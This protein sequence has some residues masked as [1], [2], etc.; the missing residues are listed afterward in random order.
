MR[1]IFPILSLILLFA[2]QPKKDPEP[3]PR[4][5]EKEQAMT[6]GYDSTLAKELGADEFGMRSYI[7]VILKKGPTPVTDSTASAEM[8]KGH[9]SNMNRLAEEGKLA[10]AGP[11]GDE[12]AGLFIFAVTTLEEAKTLTE[13]DPTIQAG[14]FIAEYHPWY[15]SAAL[16][17]MSELHGRIAKV[18][19]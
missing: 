12:W 16:M 19:I 9:F 18:E 11:F 10:M 14:H 6:M 7:L 2:C 8:F 17:Q 3:A 5:G 1:Y 4:P 15:G 13:S